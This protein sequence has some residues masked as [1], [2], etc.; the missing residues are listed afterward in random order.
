[1]VRAATAEV[2]TGRRQTLAL[3]LDE[4]GPQI[5]AIPGRDNPER[6]MLLINDPATGDP[7]EYC[8]S[9]DKVSMGIQAGTHWDALSHVS[10]AGQLYNGFP[11]SVIDEAGAHHLGID[12]VKTIVGRGV[13]LDVARAKGVDRLPDAYAITGDDLD[14][15]AELG[16]LV[17]RSGDIVFVRTG[18]MRRFRAGDKVGYYPPCAGLSLQ[19]VPW[20]RVHDIAAVGTDNVTCEV[21]PPEREDALLPVH[22]MHLVEMGMT[23]GQNFD[24]EGLSMDCSEDGRYS[25]FVDASPPPFTRALGTPVNPVVIK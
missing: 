14:E 2:R 22:L 3:P 15:A 19:S 23:Q 11:A 5:G 6:T 10:Y 13:L 7:T 9:D 1:V 18:Q 24:L 4:D 25:F 20:F 8:T 12:K 16:K 17:V 21:Y